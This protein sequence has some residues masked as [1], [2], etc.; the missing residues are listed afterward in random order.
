VVVHADQARQHGVALQVHDL[1]IAAT[2]A[3]AL[4]PTDWILPPLITMV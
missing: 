1:N 4:G 3:D 2:L